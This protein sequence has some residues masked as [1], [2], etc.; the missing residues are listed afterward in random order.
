MRFYLGTH[1]EGWLSRA[2]VPLF[3]SRARLTRRKR[4]KLPR[5][6]AP[7]ALD[8]G[9]FTML[10]NPPHRWSVSVDEYVEEVQRFAAEIGL[11]EWAAPMD[12]MCEPFII[13]RTGLSVREH[14]ERTVQNYLDLRGRGPF[15]PVLQG[16]T[17]ADYETCLDLYRQAGV[18]LAAEALVGLGSVCRRSHTP[19]IGAIVRLIEQE[20]IA[21][22]GFGVK[23]AGLALY[24]ER[25]ASADSMAW[26]YRARR[27]PPLPGH[28]HVS[29]GNCL[30]FALRWREQTVGRGIQLALL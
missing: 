4:V 27:S 19:E 6:V 16:W 2:G 7:W 23:R 1:E 10:N 11:M 8:S 12:Y 17:L 26:S 28:T 5:A 15:I 24:G 29:C 21:G 30:E 18:D 9:G 13:E 14:Q 25:L 3:I 22:H 20:G